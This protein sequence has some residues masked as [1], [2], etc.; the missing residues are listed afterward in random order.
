MASCPSCRRPVAVARAACLYCGA[1]LPLE[2][3]AEAREPQARAAG[4]GPVEVERSL[5]VLD[6]TSAPPEVLAR[7]LSLPPYEAGLLARRGGLHLHRA[8]DPAAA[9]AEA[10]RIGAQGVAAFAVPEAEVRARPR[11]CL[12]GAR[13]A[14]SLSLRTEEGPVAVRRGD[15][16][17][18]VRGAIAREYQP[19]A[20]RRRVQ[21]ARLEEGY[22][23]HLH[24]RG[25]PGGEAPR[26]VEIDAASFE[27][28]F[29]V[30]G[31]ARLEVDAW[32]GEV[33]GD[34]RIDECFRRLPPA[35]GPAEPEVKGA[36]AA[37]SS[38]GL[39]SRGRGRDDA[40][41]VLDNGEQ[42]R[43]YSGWRAAVER[44]R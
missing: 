27:F 11:R 26:P 7:A 4:A 14:G 21:T 24:L 2:A 22:R 12:G 23:V 1:P 9:R 38:L 28:G 44:R 31:S 3:T 37:A 41:V 30:T 42:F 18:V 34:A 40:P 19:T 25:H 39:A 6:V 36:L 5:V 33:A 15:V 17:L 13:G 10:A 43:C 29:A 35:L 32:V 16:L 8:L 20:R